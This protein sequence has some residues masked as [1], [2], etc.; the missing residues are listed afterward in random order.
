MPD[1]HDFNIRNGRTY[2]YFQGEPLYPFGHG[3]SYTT[4]TYKNLQCSSKTLDPDGK[5]SISVD[6]TNSGNRDGDEVVQAYVHVDGGTA[7]RPIKQ[8]VYFD[9]V[10][11]KVGET[12]TIN[13]DLA[14]DNIAL[15]YW[16]Q[17]KY[18]FVVDPATVDA[19]V[20]A[21]S[22][23]IRLRDRIRLTLRTDRR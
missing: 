11:I 12:R 9:R 18:K 23:D 21:S 1:F 15:K 14:Y 13:F 20:G 8:L 22:A 10:H 6:V 16:D 5:I 4:F 19:M 7:I 2:M 17:D 3:L